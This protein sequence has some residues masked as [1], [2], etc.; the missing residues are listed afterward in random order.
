M[1]AY[2]GFPNAQYDMGVLNLD[3]IGMPQDRDLAVA[4]FRKAAD[5]G[6]QAAAETLREMGEE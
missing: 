2:Q 5:N 1:A 4:W 3:G 6:L